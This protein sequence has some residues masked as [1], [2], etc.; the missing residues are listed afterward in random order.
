MNPS[1]NSD[2]ALKTCSKCNAIKLPSDFHS[3]GGRLDS[4]C[5]LCKRAAAKEN[6][7]KKAKLVNIPTTQGPAQLTHQPNTMNI[8]PTFSFTDE[9]KSDIN[10][11]NKFY[12][13]ELNDEEN[14]EIKRNLTDFLG[15]LDDIDRDG[16]P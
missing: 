12:G 9:A 2:Q 13:R 5:K 15:V 1:S 14:A 6:Y 4:W 8:E 11:W 16:Q 7:C 3:K 10:I